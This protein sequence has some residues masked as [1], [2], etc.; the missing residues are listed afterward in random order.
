MSPHRLPLIAAL[1]LALAA[2]SVGPD[3]VRP[4]AEL[5]T[6]FVEAVA[7][8]APAEALSIRTWQA[9]DDPVLDGLIATALIGAT[10]IAAADARLGEARALAGLTRQAYLP[11]ATVSG[12]GERSQPS[13]R[14]P[15][16]PPDIGNTE[17]WRLGFDAG[18]EI[19][20]FGSLRR[21]TEA[22]RAEVRAAEA[23][24]RA[25]RQSVV[26]E[27]AQAYFALLGAQAE[28]R[29]QARNVENLKEN[30]A[31]LTR[32]V[33][34]GRGTTLD[35][36]R[37]NALGL[38]AAAE[39]PRI[40]AEVVRHEQRLAVL[41]GLSIRELRERLGAERPMPTLPALV[42]VGTPEDWLRRRPDVAAAEARLA[43]AT[44]RIGVEQAELWP[45]LTL[46]GSFGATAQSPGDL[47]A[48]SA[49]R[50]SFGPSLSWR[51]LDFGRIRQLVL[52][53]EA[54]AE[55][56]YVAWEATLRRALEE[57]ETALAQW[58]AAQQRADALT[59]AQAAANESL[60][61]ARIRA[62]AGASQQLEVLDAERTKLD[63][64]SRA[65]RVLTERATALAAL[66]KA[67]AGDFAEA[68]PTGD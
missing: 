34:A 21:Q 9:F 38:N 23:D 11:S 37:S 48:A 15:F 4:T 54:R 41:T 13:G 19:D 51:V 47:G 35:L 58:R 28:Q 20:L 49:E 29:A 57:T 18:W 61:L 43:A 12:S 17:S 64:D 31:T 25:A 39:L 68:A 53:Q 3:F 16:I 32:G 44:A 8:Q 66:Y 14:D 40:E 1:S 56:A 22:I 52:A 62:D 50:W 67:L 42:A 46:S 2:C 7:A 63:I 27:T 55:G 6:D 59:R 5:P 45:K 26:A 36:A 65:A 30:I 10:D 60:R 33:E 24:S